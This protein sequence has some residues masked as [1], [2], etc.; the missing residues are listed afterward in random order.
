MRD[1]PSD[2]PDDLTPR[3]DA[4][5]RYRDRKRVTRM[6]VDNAG[7]KRTALALARRRVPRHDPP[8]PADDGS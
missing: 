8:A 3:E 7:V 6:V 1:Q 4:R 2:T 5:L